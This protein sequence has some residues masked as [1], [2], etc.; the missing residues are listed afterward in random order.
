MRINHVFAECY[1]G[2]DDIHCPYAHHESYEYNGKHYN[3][4]EEA[5]EAAS[6]RYKILKEF[7]SEPME[8]CVTC[9]T[10]GRCICWS[11]DWDDNE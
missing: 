7:Y 3:T 8:G 2:C 9:E 1:S 6:A 10:H 11:E 5:Q 4:R